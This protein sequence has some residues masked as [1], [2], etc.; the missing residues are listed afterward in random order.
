[1]AAEIIA[2]GGSIG[3]GLG[4]LLDQGRLLS[5]MSTVMAAILAILAVGIL[6][7]LLVFAPIERR[8]LQ[9][10]GLLAGSTR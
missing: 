5:D 8:L 4:S 7:E 2:V 9:R 3:F 6:I 10:R 1:M